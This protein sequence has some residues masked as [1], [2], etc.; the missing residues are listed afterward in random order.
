MK[1]RDYVKLIAEKEVYA[2]QG[3][4]KGMD[5]FITTHKDSR[6]CF[7]VEFYRESVG[8]APVFININ[9]EDLELIKSMPDYPD[10]KDYDKVRLIHDR[11]IYNQAGV[12]KGAEGVVE[13]SYGNGADVEFGGELYYDD[14]GRLSVKVNIVTVYAEDL[15][16]ID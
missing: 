12:Y 6:G 3:I 9:A 10:I 7:T 5:G 2:R 13:Q 14:K 11:P 15:E 16:I 4:H 8:Y 1:R